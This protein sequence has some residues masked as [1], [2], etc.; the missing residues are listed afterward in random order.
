MNIT[1]LNLNPEI[2]F[3]GRLFFPL[4]VNHSFCRKFLKALLVSFFVFIYST[5][6]YAQWLPGYTYRKK[7]T[8][9]ENKIPG[10]TA[11]TNFPVLIDIT[12][13]HL[14]PC[15]GGG[16]IENSN[17]W[18]I[19]FT[20]SSGVQLNHDIEG[21]NSLSGRL[22]VW[23]QIPSLSATSNT[24]IYL[25]FGNP[26]ITAN[27]SSANTWDNQ[28]KAVWHLNNSISD[29]SV[30]SQTSTNF[31]STN[32]SANILDGR[33]FV[34]SS[35]QY[36]RVQYDNE[37]DFNDQITVSA[38][39]NIN[40]TGIDQKIFSDQDGNGGGYKLGLYDNKKAEFEIRTAGNTAVLNRNEPGGTELATSTWYYV[41][42]VYSNP[43]NFIRTY[44]NGDLD[45]S[46]TTNADAGLTNSGNPAIGREPW[47]G[48]FF[49]DGKIDELRVQRAARDANW[50]KTEYNNQS[51]PS[52]FYST[53]ATESTISALCKNA[54]L[55]LSA[56]G[57]ATLTVP[58]IDNGSS[59]G[60][61]VT[62]TLSKTSFTC[63]DLGPN[64][65]I[66]TVSNAF[67][68]STCSA[69]VT[70]VDPVAP[71]ISG[72]PS[73]LTV[74]SD[75]GSC[76]AIV[77]WTEPTAADNCT[78]A[79]SIIWTKSKLPGTFF[80]VGTTTVTYTARD[81]SGNNSAPCSFTVTVNDNIPS[82]VSCPVTV[83][84]NAGTNNACRYVHSGTGWDA[85]AID[86]CSGVS[87]S[88]TLA[89]ATTGTGNTL[90]NVAFN[91]GL[92]TVTWTA[93]DAANNTASCKIGRAHV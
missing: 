68:S 42:G 4:P 28:Y 23:V 55:N 81:A 41:V 61:S 85:T 45:R 92:T 43:G 19:K 27:S 15:S 77:S 59:S 6:V 33:N 24:D 54:T 7:I 91:A 40:T 76:G 88:Y 65:V 72:C 74:S 87:L 50:L 89:G 16:Y 36:I 90:N 8:I 25:Y 32:T 67:G 20:T 26:S 2:T 82:S 13:P 3:F 71:V 10:T 56:S 57:S 37:L 84:Q 29:A 46:L 86:N 63:A 52:T 69:T 5:D 48:S 47:T 60:C 9:Q 1:D 79:G 17:G 34:R 58:M 62:K 21:Y 22:T 30:Y 44:V 18:D 70:V 93:T 12:D 35:N 64:N 83:Q 14:K 31:G 38:W 73:N 53:D 80:P 78:P 11:L 66:L 75:P 51:S 39:I 49:F